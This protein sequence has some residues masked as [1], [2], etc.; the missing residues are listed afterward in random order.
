MLM[1]TLSILGQNEGTYYNVLDDEPRFMRLDRM[2]SP[3]QI[4]AY[5]AGD[6]SSYGNFED[7]QYSFIYNGKYYLVSYDVSVIDYTSLSRGER[8][9][10]DIWLF[11]WNGNCWVKASIE[12][13]Q[14]DYVQTD[15]DGTW[16]HD[17]YHPRSDKGTVIKLNQNG[18]V[19][20]VLT[21][22]QVPDRTKPYDYS[23]EERVFN[24]VPS[25]NGMYHVSASMY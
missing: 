1:V 9:E 7:N 12:P 13:L 15:G 5:I 19:M 11:T 14:T 20:I 24:L 16:S 21:C 3:A 18:S 23:V 25:H 8:K 6:R 17:L 2:F 22:V 10:R 4:N